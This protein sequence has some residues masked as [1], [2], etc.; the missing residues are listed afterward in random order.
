VKSTLFK[1]LKKFGWLNGLSVYA[2]FKIK[3]MDDIRLRGIHHPLSLRP[4]TSDKPTFHQVF[5]DDEYDLAFPKETRVIID[6]GANIGLF[7]VFMKNKFPEALVICVEPDS[8]NF[9]L[10][11]KNLSGYSDT[12]FENC[13]L[14]HTDAD[15]YVYDKYKTGKWGLVVEEATDNT[16]VRGVSIDYLTKK[17]AIKKIDVLKIDIE[18]SERMLFSK[19][20][21]SWL[22]QT[23]MIIIELHDWIEEGCS[24]PFFEAI[25][26][27]I[28]RYEFTIQGENVI[29]TNLDLK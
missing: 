4:N 2:K 24:K 1:F 15:L 16:N 25:N 18:T 22:S 5:L 28:H 20:Y 7:S 29:I 17:Y 3:K 8:E 6:G 10:T 23:K 27:S 12:H 13:G 9:Q 21:E 11:K 14:W 19:N 26:R